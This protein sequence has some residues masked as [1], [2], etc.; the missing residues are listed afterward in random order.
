MI[1]AGELDKTG[2]AA[3]PMGCVF[4]DRPYTLAI[5]SAY[6]DCAAVGRLAV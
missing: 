2:S 1:V 4:A 3:G 5:M 6:G